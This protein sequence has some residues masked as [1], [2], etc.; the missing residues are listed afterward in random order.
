MQCTLRHLSLRVINTGVRFSLDWYVCYT[1]MELLSDR[2]KFNSPFNGIS[3]II[4][5]LGSLFHW[6]FCYHTI[7]GQPISLVYIIIIPLVRSPFNCISGIIPLLGS[8]YSLVFCY[9]IT[10]GQL[11]LQDFWYYTTI[12]QSISPVFCYCITIGQLIL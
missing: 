11:I 8:P 10:I 7:I 12:G 5:L 4:S 1:T 3:V 9:C 6:Y 2:C